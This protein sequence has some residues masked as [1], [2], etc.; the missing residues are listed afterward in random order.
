MAAADNTDRIRNHRF[1]LSWKFPTVVVI[2]ILL[3]VA[4]F[5][6]VAVAQTEIPAPHAPIRQSNDIP[7]HQP[8]LMSTAVATVG[9][10]RESMGKGEEGKRNFD[11]LAMIIGALFV[12]FYSWGRFNDPGTIRSSTTQARYFYSNVSYAM[13]Y[14]CL[15][16]ILMKYADVVNILF[17]GD[18][19]LQ[20]EFNNLPHALVAALL[21]TGFLQRI[22]FLQKIDQWLRDNLQRL[23][24]IPFEVRRLTKQLIN[25]DFEIDPNIQEIVYKHLRQEGLFCDSINFNNRSES[26]WLWNKA[27]VLMYEISLWEQKSRMT[28][29]M[30]SKGTDYK[31]IK[32]KYNNMADSA[33][34]NLELC[35]QSANPSTNNEALNELARKFQEECLEL[36]ESQCQFIS[37]GILR[38]F[39]SYKSRAAELHG[40]GFIVPNEDTEHKLTLNQIT[41][42]FLALTVG[43]STLFV[44]Y[45]RLFEINSDNFRFM[46]LAIIQSLVAV[47]AVVYTKG[48]WEISKLDERKRLPIFYY[49]VVGLFTV[50]LCFPVSF[51]YRSLYE[52]T[53]TATSNS[54]ATSK[55]ASTSKSASKPGKQTGLQKSKPAKSKPGDADNENKLRQFFNYIW[56]SLKWKVSAFFIAFCLAVQLDFSRLGRLQYPQLRWVDGAV[57][58]AV[59]ILAA[60]LTFYLLDHE[61]QKRVLKIVGLDWWIVR[62]AVIGFIIGCTIPYWYKVAPRGITAEPEEEP[63]S[64][65]RRS[66]AV[67]SHK[68]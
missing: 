53:S 48:K 9:H 12:I 10:L 15:F 6:A 64:Q 21:L 60:I 67:V 27:S 62:G 34:K 31:D 11:R 33:K 35:A 13:V 32:V 42:L 1:S 66:E 14:L 37:H 43:L 22:P 49:F 44:L 26:Y 47:S 54:A 2:G 65:L 55:A 63:I 40:M 5:S 61:L 36:I 51:V 19:E 45:N 52:L 28:K 39:Y 16:A 23:A 18:A 8:S 3:T 17:E 29:F 4:G 24:S 68:A 30:I 20:N 57:Q 7:F 59:G 38:H 56:N 46:L 25:A 50:A 58:A 41:A